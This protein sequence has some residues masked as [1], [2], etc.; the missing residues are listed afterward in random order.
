V[1]GLKALVT[2]AA[3]FLGYHVARHLLDRG[4]SVVLVDN[5]VRG[6]ADAAYAALTRHPRAEAL[7]LD[8]N[9]A[10]AVRRALPPPD[11]VETIF[12]LAA[13]NGTQNFYERPLAV[14]RCC[15]LPAFALLEWLAN[16]PRREPGPRFVYAGSSESY[17]ATVDRFGWA[18]P[19][20]EDVP[21]CIGDVANPRWSYAVSKLHGEVLT[22]Q[23]CRELG[24]PWT[25][26]RYH[27]AYG[28]RMGDKHVMPDF[29]VRARDEGRCA[30][31]GHAETR[32]F[33][34]VDDAVAATLALAAH[35]D[36][37]GEV[38][39]VGGA[40]EIAIADLGR[41]MMRVCGL[42]GPL[43]LHP[44]PAG[45]VRRRAPDLSKLRRLTGFEETVPLEDGIARTAA[46]YL[47]RA[48]TAAHTN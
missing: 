28:P 26:V 16:A 4:D 7:D 32:S 10:A 48:A 45:S 9:D 33:I 14:L 42:D 34:Y 3:G 36:A 27:N 2:G 13:L 31:Y 15:T 41:M 1:A 35:P 44:A 38:V 20:A 40:Q 19:T 23:G 24:L 8:L 47:G 17:A 21:L 6:E 46:F 25:V 18:V 11:E 22:A 29:L 43:E 39:N 5:F 30:L 37:A 12:H